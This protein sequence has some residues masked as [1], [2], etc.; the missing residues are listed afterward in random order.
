MGGS[1]PANLSSPTH[2][3]AGQ[4][5]GFS[6]R[7]NPP[8]GE[9]PEQGLRGNGQRK[10]RAHGNDTRKVSPAV[11]NFYDLVDKAVEQLSSLETQRKE[12]QLHKTF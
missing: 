11:Q 12:V 7:H 10:R 8:S 4:N 6:G 1:L 3:H 2:H 9:G 5:Q